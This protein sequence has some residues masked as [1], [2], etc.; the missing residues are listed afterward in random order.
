MALYQTK[1]QDAL[2]FLISLYHPTIKIAA[3]EVS[4][5]FRDINNRYIGSRQRRARG[6]QEIERVGYAVRETAKNEHRHAEQQRKHLALAGKLH[7]GSHYKS[8]SDSQ[9]TACQHSY[10]H[11]AVDYRHG[12][13]YAIGLRVE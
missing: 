13:R 7:G 2:C 4:E 12:R 3:D 9:N 11:T 6:Q 5:Y 10:F 8:A 1:K